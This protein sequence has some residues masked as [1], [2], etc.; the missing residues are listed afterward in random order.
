MALHLVRHGPPRP[1]PDVPA[2]EWHLDP[3]EAAAVDVLGASG[4]LPPRARWCSSDAPKC[5]E[6]ARRLAAGA[7]VEVVPDLREQV[8]PA[9]WLPDYALRVHRSLVRTDEPPAEGWETGDSTR[10]RVL[11]AVRDLVDGT[12]GDL[13]LVGHAVAWTFAVSELTGGTTD[14]AAWE[15]MAMPDHCAIDGDR[16]VEPWGTWQRR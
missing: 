12:A 16:L 4:V 8:R 14:L 2:H 10:S 13:V 15:R 5:L 1:D 9:G 7:D 6:T 3:A 11:D